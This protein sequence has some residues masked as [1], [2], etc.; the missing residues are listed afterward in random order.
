MCGGDF[1]T[2]VRNRD[3]EDDRVEC[4]EQSP[5]GGLDLTRLRP[6]TVHLHLHPLVDPA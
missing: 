6:V 3:G 4:P 5:Q 1:H 2:A